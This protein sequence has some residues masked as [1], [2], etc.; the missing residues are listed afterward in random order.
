M[1]TAVGE[2]DTLAGGTTFT[3]EE[4]DLLGSATLVAV[5]VSVVA[6]LGAVRTPP[7]VIVP[8]LVAHVT[9]VFP[10]PPLTEAVNVCCWP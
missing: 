5:T 8:A 6:V 9:A 1:V 4:A 2:R 10:V 7:A 3:V